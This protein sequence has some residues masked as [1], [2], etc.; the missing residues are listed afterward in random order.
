MHNEVYVCLFPDVLYTICMH[1]VQF[2]PYMYTLYCTGG[3]QSG[4]LQRCEGESGSRHG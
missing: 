1:N 4:G 3:A 2:T